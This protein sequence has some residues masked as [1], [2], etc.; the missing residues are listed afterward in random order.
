MQDPAQI[1]VTHKN[2]VGHGTAGGAARTDAAALLEA[3][4][5]RTSWLPCCAY[6]ALP[7]GDG[8]CATLATHPSLPAL[9]PP[10]P[11]PP[12][13]MMLRRVGTSPA[14]RVQSVVSDVLDSAMAR[15]CISAEQREVL[16]RELALRLEPL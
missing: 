9:P 4:R 3:L 13:A 11:L 2:Q 15:G 6:A 8:A 7:T 14:L 12:Q 10:P 1:V 5:Q 16:E